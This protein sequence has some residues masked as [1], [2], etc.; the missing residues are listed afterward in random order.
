MERDKEGR[1]GSNV[2]CTNT[3]KI[4]WFSVPHFFHAGNRA[5]VMFKLYFMLLLFWHNMVELHSW[6]PK[7]L[8]K[9]L[10]VRSDR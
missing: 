2:F 6:G 9:Y 3:H 10:I 1:E 5:N 4:F 8:G 7:A